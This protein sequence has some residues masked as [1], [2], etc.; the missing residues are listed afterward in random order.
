M[1]TIAE[2][3]QIISD[4]TNAIKQAILDRGGSVEGGL[5]NYANSVMKIPKI[6]H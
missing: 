6:I 1:S 3:L 4:S 2:N 5:I